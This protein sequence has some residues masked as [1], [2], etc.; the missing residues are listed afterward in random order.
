MPVV[1]S[2]MRDY[3]VTLLKIEPSRDPFSK[4]FWYFWKY[5]FKRIHKELYILLLFTKLEIPLLLP[6]LFFNTFCVDV[7]TDFSVS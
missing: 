7:P 6:F 4:F 2:I 5:Y 3:K 1:D